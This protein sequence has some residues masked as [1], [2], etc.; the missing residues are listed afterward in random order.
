MR[1]GPSVGMPEATV[2]LPHLGGS[3]GGRCNDDRERPEL[4]DRAEILW[5]LARDPRMSEQQ[6]GET[7]GRHERRKENI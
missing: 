7:A 5:S 1:G 6:D 3:G 2:L 4:K